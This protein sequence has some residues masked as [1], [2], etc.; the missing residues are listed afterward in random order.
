M[1]PK[2]FSSVALRF[3]DSQAVQRVDLCRS[4]PIHAQRRCVDLRRPDSARFSREIAITPPDE[5][6]PPAMKLKGYG[7]PRLMGH[8]PRG[9]EALGTS[10]DGR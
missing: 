6:M 2:E 1:R 7:P 5:P 10:N 8:L 4:I 3:S 9:A